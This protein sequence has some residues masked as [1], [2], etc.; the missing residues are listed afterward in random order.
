MLQIRRT[1]L[2]TQLHPLS[3]ELAAR[4]SLSLGTVSSESS[5]S[6]EVV[7][8]LAFYRAR[9]ESTERW[10]GDGLPNS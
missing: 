1:A 2:S 6:I 5:S 9:Q 3:L 10:C 8:Q 7:R 4:I